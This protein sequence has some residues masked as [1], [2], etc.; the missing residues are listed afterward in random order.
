MGARIAKPIRRIQAAN[1]GAG[2]AGLAFP[3]AFHGPQATGYLDRLS[4]HPLRG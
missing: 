4:I 2:S 3:A 1:S